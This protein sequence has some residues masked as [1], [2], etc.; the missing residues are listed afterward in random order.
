M[1][2]VTPLY[3]EINTLSP[4]FV[5]GSLECLSLHLRHVLGHFK[6]FFLT[7]TPAHCWRSFH[8]LVYVGMPRCV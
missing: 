4:G 2:I 7:G 6:G 5:S 1:D 8:Q 3:F